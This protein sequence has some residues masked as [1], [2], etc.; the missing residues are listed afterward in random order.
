[1]IVNIISEPSV[2]TDGLSSLPTDTRWGTFWGGSAAWRISREKFWSESTINDW[3]N[4][5]RIRASYATIGNS[6]LGNYFPYLGTY[7]AKKAGSNTAIAWNRMGNSQFK[8]ETTDF[9]DT[10]A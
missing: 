8:W 7:G 10:L 2:R 4:D 9:F 6:D 5:L 1:M 3:F